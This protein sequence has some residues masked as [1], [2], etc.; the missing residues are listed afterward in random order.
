MKRSRIPLIVAVV[1][2]GLALRSAASD[3]QAWFEDALT[4]NVGNTWQLKGTHEL[5]FD[6]T[7]YDETLLQNFS[8][9]LLRKLP[10]DTSLGVF[11]KREK[12]RTS[13]GSRLEDRYFADVSWA[14]DVARR[15]SF[16]TRLRTELRTFRRGAANDVIRFRLRMRI[17][18]RAPMGVLRVRPF[19]WTELFTGHD[20]PLR[21][22]FSAGTVFQ[23]NPHVGIVLSYIRQDTRGREAL[24]IV[25]T[26]IELA[27]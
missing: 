16:D 22:R 7:S 17:R 13:Q 11:Y 19:A 15:A 20:Q 25:N 23:I 5:R 8:V 9:G 6:K 21:N 2:F 24:N 27:F 14:T 12:E 26:G 10:W 3:G 1:F 18:T 4:I